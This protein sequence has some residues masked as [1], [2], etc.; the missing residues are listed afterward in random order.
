MKRIVKFFRKPPASTVQGI[1]SPSIA[2][3]MSGQ[4]CTGS[5]DFGGG[6]VGEM[7]LKD[8]LI[9]I[10]KVDDKGK[11]SRNFGRTNINGKIAAVEGS[12]ALVPA[13]ACFGVVVDEVEDEET[14][15]SQP[16]KPL[17]R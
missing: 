7:E 17:R 2:Y 16:A 4:R 8:G 3:V 14:D 11:P 1:A 12:Y 9:Q 15:L 6:V 5:A 13:T 10:R